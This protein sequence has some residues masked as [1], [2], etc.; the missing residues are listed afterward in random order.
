MDHPTSMNRCNLPPWAI[1][2][3]HYNSK[4]QIIEIQG[5]RHNGRPLFE[6]LDAHLKNSMH[7]MTQRNV[8]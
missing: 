8:G 5:V 6:K 1:A 7:R 2:S 4:P 3:K